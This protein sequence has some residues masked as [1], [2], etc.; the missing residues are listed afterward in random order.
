MKEV[1]LT[2]EAKMVVRFEEDN[3][4]IPDQID[5]ISIDF[6]EGETIEARVT[7]FDIVDEKHIKEDN[8]EEE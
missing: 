6:P 4:F 3:T 8:E 2:I 1:I 5:R 7:D